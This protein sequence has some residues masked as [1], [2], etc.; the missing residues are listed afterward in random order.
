MKPRVNISKVNQNLF[1]LAA[2]VTEALKK[3]G[4]KQQA[5]EMRK[6]VMTCSSFD[7]ALRVAS[8]YVD[9]E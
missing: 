7:E 5:R 2:E 4:L 9:W 3:A 8:D 1:S 6:K